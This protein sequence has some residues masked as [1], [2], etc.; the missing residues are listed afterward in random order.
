MRI[1]HI[2]D[3]DW[4]DFN[5]KILQ[6]FDDGLGDLITHRE[7][8]EDLKPFT[9]ITYPTDNGTSR[10][11][12]VSLDGEYEDDIWIEIGRLN[13]EGRMKYTLFTQDNGKSSIW[14][15]FSLADLESDLNDCFKIAIRNR[16]SVK[17]SVKQDTVSDFLKLC[18]GK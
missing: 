17:E 9:Y 1:T 5:H 12:E 7:R 16:N 2:D 18:E 8:N 6:F 14:T 3:A 4:E 13:I 15:G 11:Y 10:C